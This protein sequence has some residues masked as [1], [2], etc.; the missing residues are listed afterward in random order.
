MGLQNP[1]R[2]TNNEDTMLK[3]FIDTLDNFCVQCHTNEKCGGCKKCPAGTLIYACKKYIEDMELYDSEEDVPEEDILEFRTL[4]DI[5]R[6]IKNIEPEPMFNDSYLS[7]DEPSED[8]LE[9]LRWNLKKLE[10]YKAKN[11]LRYTLKRD[12]K[13]IK[14]AVKIAQ[15]QELDD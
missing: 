3:T 6:V 4:E 12:D 14:K 10:H 13:D 11:V 9:K 2:Y 15:I 7:Q 1:F 5:K 8:I